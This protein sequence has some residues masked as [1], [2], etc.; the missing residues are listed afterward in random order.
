MERRYGKIC[1]V[2]KFKYLGDQTQVTKKPSQCKKN[3]TCIS[4]KK[5]IYNK[6][7]VSINVKLRHY[8]TIIIPEIHYILECLVLNMAKQLNGIKTRKIL[9]KIIRPKYE[10]GMWKI[11]IK[12]FIS[13]QRELCPQ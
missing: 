7:Y 11:R 6:E 13:K 2:A 5:N 1:K 4:A 8:N 3:G 12:K 10:N 9:R